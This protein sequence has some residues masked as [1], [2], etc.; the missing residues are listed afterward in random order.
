MAWKYDIPELRDLLHENKVVL[1]EKDLVNSFL[2]WKDEDCIITFH[3][4]TTDES[5]EKLSPKRGNETYAKNKR[6]VAWEINKGLSKMRFDFPVARSRNIVRAVHLLMITLTFDPKKVSKEEAWHLLTTKGK[7]FNRFSANLSKMFG[8]KATWKIKEAN[9]SGYPAPHIFVMLDKP[10]R[11]FR[12]HG[13]WRLQSNHILERLRGVW[14]Y[15]FIDVEAIVDNKVKKRKVVGYL[16]KYLTKSVSVS[17]KD[18]KMLDVNDLGKERIAILT[19]AW[20]KV[21]RSRD[22]LSK[23]FKQ[24]LNFQYKEKE[25]RLE[26]E[27]WIIEDI[28]YST[29][30]VKSELVE[31]SGIPNNFYRPSG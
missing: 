16:T 26:P 22:I 15:G 4:D 19:H 12:F 21:Y 20:N 24:R 1:N 11:A 25:N 9:S 6:K 14:R 7:A 23:S 17:R 8:T 27:Q 29:L 31:L 30:I 5:Y 18:G 13:K 10:I 28:R 2:D 3:N